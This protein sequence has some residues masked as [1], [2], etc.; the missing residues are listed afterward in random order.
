MQHHSRA[1]AETQLWQLVNVLLL[2]GEFEP[3]QLQ[4][5]TTLRQ[6]TRLMVHVRGQPGGMSF[7]N[8]VS[9]EAAGA[10]CRGSCSGHCRQRIGRICA[11]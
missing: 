1:E 9:D 11:S 3:D 6:L 5:L 2:Q 8:L 4:Q 10:G 7:S